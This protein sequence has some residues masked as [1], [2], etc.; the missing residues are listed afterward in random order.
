MAGF[1]EEE[2]VK[3]ISFCFVVEFELIFCHPCFY[4]NCACTE[5]FGDIIYVICKRLMMSERGVVYWTKRMG[6]SIN[7]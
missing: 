3:K 6:P 1:N 5:F 2:K 4:V 7:P